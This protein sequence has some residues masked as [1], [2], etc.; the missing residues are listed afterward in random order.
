MVGVGAA[1]G[2]TVG[3]VV[4]SDAVL[5]DTVGAGAVGACVVDVD[6]VGAGVDGGGGDDGASPLASW[7]LR[8]SVTFRAKRGRSSSTNSENVLRKLFKSRTCLSCW[9]I[10]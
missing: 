6:A 4:V 2:G 5:G 3:G 8:A 1:V 9:K 7:V 10:A